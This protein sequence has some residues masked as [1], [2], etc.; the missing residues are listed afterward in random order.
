MKIKNGK[1]RLDEHEKRIG[2]FVVRLDADYVKIRDIGGVFIFS[3]S[4]KCAIG[5]FLKGAWEDFKDEQTS[6]GI[7]NY[8]AVLWS[9]F[10]AVPDVDFL[11]DAYKAAEDCIRRHPEAYGYTTK[12]ISDKEDAEIIEGMKEMMEFEK[13]VNNLPESDQ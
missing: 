6:K 2:N 13:E 3:A 1:I 10:S 12:D 4:T 8:I 11:T 9:V 5:M 7:G